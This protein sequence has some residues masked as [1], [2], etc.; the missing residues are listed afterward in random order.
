MND[1]AGTL[2]QWQRYISD[3]EQNLSTVKQHV[4]TV[5]NSS[6]A[7]DA[8]KQQALSDYME[9]KRYL[10]WLKAKYAEYE[11]TGEIPADMTID[12]N[13]SGDLYRYNNE[14]KIAE[15]PLDTTAT[16]EIYHTIATVQRGTTQEFTIFQSEDLNL[17]VSVTAYQTENA[18][19]RY[20]LQGGN[21]PALIIQAEG[22]ND[23]VVTA[24]GTWAE[25]T[26]Y[27][28][29]APG[30]NSYNYYAFGYIYPPASFYNIPTWGSSTS[31]L[32]G[33]KGFT[34]SGS[35]NPS[36]VIATGIISGS[37]DGTVDN[38]WDFYDDNIKPEDP[39]N[40]VFPD[41]WTPPGPGNDPD[42][43]PEEEMAPDKT[44]WGD[45]E[46]P[47]KDFYPSEDF[48]NYAAFNAI[49]INQLKVSLWDAPDSFW[50]A[51][52]MLG[53]NSANYLDYLVS[54]RVYP[55]DITAPGDFDTIYLGRGGQIF[56]PGGEGAYTHYGI[57][58]KTT[59]FPFEINAEKYY[60]N[61]LDFAPYTKAELYLPFS[62][63]WEI[64]PK[65]VYHTT[66]KIYLFLDIT[67]G[68]GVWK[69]YNA[70]HS[71]CI[72]IKQC[73]IGV[74]LPLS[75]ND[76]I[77]QSS[78]IVN[79]TLGLAQTITG[80]VP[81][82]VNSTLS[83]I[84]AAANEETNNLNAVGVGAGIASQLTNTS[85]DAL[86][87]ATNLANANR[88][89]PCYTGGTT[90]LAAAQQGLFPTLTLIRPV[91]ENPESFPHT[92]GNLVNQTHKLEELTGYTTCRNVDMSNVPQA[93]DKEKAQLKKILENGFYA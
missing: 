80:G 2:K 50:D 56:L 92:V 28:P 15:I 7:T 61:F 1:N 29:L 33:V 19:V 16:P 49:G 42:D 76:A 65:Y 57:P 54:L 64:N 52:S 8:E 77:G 83:A 58:M 44:D 36:R 79:A 73:K 67:D 63:V 70:E 89:I 9:Q 6:T 38:P 22:M 59:L 51:L 24:T 60:N 25:A 47:W 78:Q 91:V 87:A 68:S 37:I 32:W 88:E 3:Y 13:F 90:G 11:E 55:Y 12:E 41:G 75:G 20:K 74:E 72:L 85:L 5:L 66:L 48:N 34:P 31:G 30:Y 14:I 4:D 27:T 39:E 23:M 84:G 10:E 71:K 69:V 26:G 46:D 62:G 81:K 40:A 21:Y 18:T 17:V 93:T 82:I 53:S 35:D 43:G 45:P 86:S